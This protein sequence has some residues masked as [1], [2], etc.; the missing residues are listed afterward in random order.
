MDFKKLELSTDQIEHA[1]FEQG[2]NILNLTIDQE[3]VAVAT[4]LSEV[5][6]NH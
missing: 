2:M 4:Y 5:L 1:L 3:S 6:E